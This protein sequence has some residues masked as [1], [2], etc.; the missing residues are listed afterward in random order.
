MRF[1]RPFKLLA[2]LGNDSLARSELEMAAEL[3]RLTYHEY[4][5]SGNGSMTASWGLARAIEH[6]TD[7]PGE[8]FGF[9]RACGWGLDVAASAYAMGDD[10]LRQRFHPWFGLVVDTV[11]A[12]QSGCGGYLQATPHHSNGSIYRIRQNYESAITDNAL[13]AIANT[14]FREFEDDKAERLDDVM[15]TRAYGTIS[16]AFWSQENGAPHGTV[17]VG[18]YDLTQPPYCGAATD[19]WA[20]PQTDTKYPWNSLAYAYELTGDQVFLDRAA[21]VANT[22]SLANFFDQNQLSDLDNRYAMLT[23]VQAI[24]EQTD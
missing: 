6:T 24:Y 8:G 22:T 14:V 18:P 9:G 10:S 7:H 12:G 19:H 17:A 13:R 21:D 20:S 1:L 2:W 5:A 15:V 4:P 3:Y 11:E 16:S 23:L